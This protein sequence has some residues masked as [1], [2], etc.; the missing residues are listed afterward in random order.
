MKSTIN[1]G[2]C[3]KEKMDAYLAL[4]ENQGHRARKE[5]HIFVSLDK[6]L[7][8]IGLHEQDLLPRIID[9]WISSLPSE[10]NVNTVNVYIAHYSQ[11]AKYLRTFGHNVF[12]PEKPIG[13]R[14]YIPYIF[15][16]NE[17]L[18]LVKAADD[19]VVSS[20]E[21]QRHNAICFSVMIRMLVGCGF[22]V[23]EIRLLKTRRI[24]L[25]RGIVY[26][27]NAKGDKDRLV[28][29]HESLTKVLK[30]YAGSNSPKA[31]DW[32]FP[33]LNAMPVPYSWIRESFNKCLGR[34]GI[35]KPDLP[36]HSRNIC[37]HCLRHSYAAAAFR[38]LD[39]DGIDLY[40]EVPILSTY[41]GHENLYGTEHYLYMT[42]ENRQDILFRME[43]LNKGL[44]PEV[45][46]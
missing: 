40:S 39:I 23:N 13:N 29:M 24:D 30:I 10:L 11:F 27:K 35:E 4:R 9:G 34:I 19:M 2:S 41:M 26:V 8:S 42:A 46:E 18:A 36:K 38:K 16:T 20:T 31:D 45:L 7:Q 44:F 33:T 32:F 21:K 6:Y 28:P 5:R 15:H 14:S 3:L 12:I 17:L 37:L 43:I 1:F 25:E 22:R